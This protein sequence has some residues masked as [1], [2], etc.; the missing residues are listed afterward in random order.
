MANKVYFDLDD[1]HEGH[2]RLEMLKWLKEEIP[3]LRVTL[4]TIPSLCSPGYPQRMAEQYSWMHLVPHGWTH[5]SN[6]EC[7]TWTK[8]VALAALSAAEKRGFTVKGFKAP[9][10]QI[11]DATYLAL[12]EK[13]YWVAD[14]K[15]NDGRRPSGLPVY[16]LDGSVKQIHG[17]VGHRGGHNP[18]ELGLILNE[19][20]AHKGAEF[21]FINDLLTNGL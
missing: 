21:G 2:P 20:R 11:S 16:R 19:V 6:Y 14:Q 3:Q 1:F 15:Y 18:N 10:W 8:P 12:V 4:F 17:H 7:K 13:G 9:G 5:D